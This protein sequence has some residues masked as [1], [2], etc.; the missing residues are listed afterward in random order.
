[1]VVFGGQGIE[2]EGEV[3]NT[4]FLVFFNLDVFLIIKREA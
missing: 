1:M 3:T 2:E 4:F